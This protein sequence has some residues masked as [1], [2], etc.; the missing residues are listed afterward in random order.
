MN[1]TR[2]KV[3]KLLTEL[4]KHPKFYVDM[5]GYAVYVIFD[6]DWKKTAE[7][8]YKIMGSCR[9]ITES[10]KAMAN[11]IR[12]MNNIDFSIMFFNNDASIDTI[13]HEC[14]HVL[15]YIMNAY[16][17]SFDIKHTELIAYLMQT[18]V[19]KTLKFQPKNFE[20]TKINW[21]CYR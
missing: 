14:T 11:R 20:P 19:S 12:T 4:A 3:K 10:T 2:N 1:F 15:T 18:L 16:N 7:K 17:L 13:C 5:Y 9:L 8:I 21:E 6:N